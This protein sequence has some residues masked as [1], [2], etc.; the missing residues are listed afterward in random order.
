M[1]GYTH[2]ASTTEYRNSH[3]AQVTHAPFHDRGFSN[4]VSIN[5]YKSENRNG[6]LQF[7]NGKI[8]VQEDSVVCLCHTAIRKQ[9]QDLTSLQC[10]HP[11]GVLPP[12]AAKLLEKQDI[13]TAHPQTSSLSKFLCSLFSKD[14]LLFS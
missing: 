12:G 4:F 9:S 8:E 6:W 14:I 3:H 2:E 5:L 13:S 10:W 7:T 1:G 11:M